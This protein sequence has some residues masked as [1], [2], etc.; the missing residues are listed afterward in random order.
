MATKQEKVVQKA[1]SREKKRGKE[2]EERHFLWILLA[3]IALLL[4]LN[5][6]QYFGWWPY[7]R[8]TL[9]SAFIRM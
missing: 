6:A 5:F 2:R 3:L 1:V 9:G 4:Y 8:P 7:P